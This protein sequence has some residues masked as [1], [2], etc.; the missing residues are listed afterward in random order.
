MARMP[1]ADTSLEIR[2]S[3]LTGDNKEAFLRFLR[4]MLQWRPEDRATAKELQ[5]DPWLHSG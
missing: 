3:T 1:A 2:E 4:R 5:K